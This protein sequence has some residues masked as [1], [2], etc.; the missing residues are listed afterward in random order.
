MPAPPWAYTTVEKDAKLAQKLQVC[1]WA[2]LCLL[3][4]YSHRNAWANLHLFC[5]NRTPFSLRWEAAAALPPPAD[6]KAARAR[7]RFFAAGHPPPTPTEKGVSLAQKVQVGPCIPAGIQ[8]EKAEVGPTSGP[9]WRLSHSL[10]T[11]SHTDA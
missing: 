8:P 3:W 1:S 6:P 7:E 5:T 9:T 2:N 4:L 11:V 10:H